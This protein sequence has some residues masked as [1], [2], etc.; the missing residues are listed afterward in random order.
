MDD[1]TQRWLAAE[2]ERLSKLKRADTRR[3]LLKIL[4][5]LALLLAAFAVGWYALSELAEDLMWAIFPYGIG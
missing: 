1:D 2:V 4:L 5:I 3:L